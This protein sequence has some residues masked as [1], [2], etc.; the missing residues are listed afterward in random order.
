MNEVVHF[1]IPADDMGRAKKFYASV[2]GW[3]LQDVSGMDYT[4]AGTVEVDEKTR[5]PKSP[6]AINGGMMKRGGA[7]KVTTLTIDVGN[8]DK[9]VQK[10][11]KAGGKLVKEKQ[12]VVDMG[13]IAY[14]EDPE[15]NVIGLW[16]T[17]MPARK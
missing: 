7:V 13:W 10:I 14:A 3:K 11:V 5:M 15:G 2:F 4:M 16:E 9:A 1:E 8:V 17:I 6:G 12:K